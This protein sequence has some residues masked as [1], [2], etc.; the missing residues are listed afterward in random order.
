M[1]PVLVIEGA[2]A[3][4]SGK[5]RTPLKAVA[6]VTVSVPAIV[7]FSSTSNVSMCA[8][9]SRYKSLN[10]VP[11]APKSMSL[12]VTGSIAPSC[13]RTC[14]TAELLTSVNIPTLL[15]LVSTTTLLRAST[16]AISPTYAPSVDVPS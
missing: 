11:D 9:P 7:A 8:V 16:S 6:P 5:V 15:L 4:P 13:I 1:S 2:E 10:S 14:S 3:E 12:S